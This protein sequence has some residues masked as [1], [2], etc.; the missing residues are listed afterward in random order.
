[1][2]QSFRIR[3]VFAATLLLSA[4]L[5]APAYADKATAGLTEASKLMDQGLPVKAIDVINQTLKSGQVPADLAA[6]GLLMRAKAQEKLGKYAYALADYNSAIWMQSLSAHDKAE[7]EQGRQQILGKLGV[8][9]SSE[10]AASAE[11]T[12][13][14]P[15]ETPKAA[16]QQA[17]GKPQ[18]PASWD[19]AVQTSP[20]EEHTSGIGSIFSGLF[21]SS[22]TAQA[23]AQPQ[24][25][26]NQSAAQH[27][28]RARPQPAKVET[29]SRA[30]AP[31]EREVSANVVQTG[32]EPSGDFAIQMAAIESE[33]RAIYEVNRVAKRYGDLLGGR[34]PSIKIKAT[35]DGGT[36]YKVV[37]EPYQ[38]GEGIA[39]CELLKT[40]GVNCMVIS[41]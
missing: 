12:P 27:V 13:P 37:A 20:S 6:K 22:K 41:K 25:E 28:E 36:L 14:P 7:A 39:T 9:G 40:K 15:A 34:T 8:S 33:D 31:Q 5:A 32:S 18:R 10:K 24:P 3:S 1:M 30:K 35:S 23:E 26:G 21:G 19:T 16:P 29:A 4:A 2:V 11:P 17:A 38:R